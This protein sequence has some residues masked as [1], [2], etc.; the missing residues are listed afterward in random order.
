MEVSDGNS[1]ETQTS[2]AA[3]QQD[4]PKSPMTGDIFEADNFS[5][6][7][8]CLGVSKNVELYIVPY[9]SISF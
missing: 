3:A 9:L 2:T 1:S 8:L 7:S 6:I 4:V 5:E